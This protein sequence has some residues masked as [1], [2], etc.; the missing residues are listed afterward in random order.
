MAREQ[1]LELVHYELEQVHRSEFHI[2]PMYRFPH[3]QSMVLL[4]VLHSLLHHV[5]LSLQCKVLRP[6]SQLN[7]TKHF[8]DIDET[9]LQGT[10]NRLSLYL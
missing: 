3:I 8:I 10:L 7:L 5:R 2:V 1:E 4:L 9:I 6:L